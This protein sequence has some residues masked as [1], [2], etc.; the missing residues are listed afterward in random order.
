MFALCFLIPRCITGRLRPS[1]SLQPLGSYLGCVVRPKDPRTLAFS[2]IPAVFPLA[3]F[4]LTDFGRL[5]LPLFLCIFKAF[6][7]HGS[8]DPNSL[9]FSFVLL[10]FL[11]LLF[12]HYRIAQ[13]VIFFFGPWAVVNFEPQHTYI[14]GIFIINS[15]YIQLMINLIITYVIKFNKAN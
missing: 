4:W 10:F 3:S 9:G 6:S 13:C 8:L 14:K 1:F 2:G 15:K 12:L 7:L 11:F 5:G